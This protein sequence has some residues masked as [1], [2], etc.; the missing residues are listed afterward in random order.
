MGWVWVSSGW[1]QQQPPTPQLISIYPAGAQTGKTVDLKIVEQSE[2]E[3][4]DGLIFSHPG[5]TAGPKMQPS[6]RFFPKP[7]AVRNVF[8]VSVGKNV[9]AGVYEVRAQ[10][11]YGISNPRRFVVSAHQEFLENEPNDNIEKANPLKAGST[12][13]GT[14][15]AGYDFYRLEIKKGQSL[16]FHCVSELIDSRGDPVMALLDSN[17]KIVAKNQDTSILDRRVTWK[18]KNNV[19]FLYGHR[20]VGSLSPGVFDLGL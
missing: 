18:N 12:V 5:I 20:P 15:E 16:V 17:Q 4:A 8:E 14:F 11:E 19:S 1:A 7:V 6:N 2:L 13:N 3:F 10:C 9:P